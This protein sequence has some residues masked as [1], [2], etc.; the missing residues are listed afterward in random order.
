LQAERN[1]A[2]KE[3]KIAKSQALEVYMKN[4]LMRGKM[5]ALQKEVVDI[6]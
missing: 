6:Q 4:E 5:E 1:I 3:A 2:L